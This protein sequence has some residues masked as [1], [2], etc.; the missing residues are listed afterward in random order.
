MFSHVIATLPARRIFEAVGEIFQ[1]HFGDSREQLDQWMPGYSI[2]EMDNPKTLCLGV[3]LTNGIGQKKGRWG[4]TEFLSDQ[5]CA[6]Q[7]GFCLRV[8]GDES[9]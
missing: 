5:K 7:K 3:S 8:S 9:D 1:R 6:L 2:A 4:F